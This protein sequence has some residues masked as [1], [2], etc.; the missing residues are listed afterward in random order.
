M[1]KTTIKVGNSN[2]LD[3]AHY[4]QMLT[5]EFRYIFGYS[6]FYKI[7]NVTLQYQL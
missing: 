4:T 2:I 3:I 7:A 6:I 5:K 1:F